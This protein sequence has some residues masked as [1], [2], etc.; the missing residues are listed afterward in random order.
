MYDEDEIM[1]SYVES[2]VYDARQDEKIEI[3]RRMLEDGTLPMD[4][5][6]QYSGLSIDEVKN[7]KADQM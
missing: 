2:E 5:I 1:R 7:I 3:A 6:A 4:K